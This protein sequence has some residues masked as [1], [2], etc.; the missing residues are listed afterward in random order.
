MGLLFFTAQVHNLIFRK[1]ELEGQ[2]SDISKQCDDA[3]KYVSAI[4]SGNVSI[5]DLLRIPGSMMGRAMNYLAFAHNNAMQYAMENAPGY[6]QMYMQ[7]SGGTQDP[8]QA[9]QM[10]NYIMNQLYEQARNQ[11]LE[12]EKQNLH[13]IE[14]EL[15]QRKEELQ[16]DLDIVNKELET[17]R[18]QRD[19]AIDDI[20][21][22]FGN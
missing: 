3:H 6:E 1:H 18:G 19:K 2:I 22:K 20:I 5:G 9:Q 7:Q 11:A 8:Q 12:Y 4:S 21:P 16:T 17:Y 13:E 10:H 15:G 14:T